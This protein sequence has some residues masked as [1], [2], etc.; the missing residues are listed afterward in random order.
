M[1]RG[2]MIVTKYGQLKS[3]FISLFEHNTDAILLLDADGYILDANPAFIELGGYVEEDFVNQHFSKFIV[4][5][6]DNNEDQRPLFCEVDLLDLRFTFITKDNTHIG[7]LMRLNPVKEN[8]TIAGYFLIIKNMTKLDKMAEHYLESELNYR[9]IAENLHDVLILMDKDKNYLYV[10]PSSYEVFKFNHTDINNRNPF[11]NIHP[12]YVNEIDMKFKAAIEKGEAFQIKLKAYHEKSGWI[13]TE[14]KGKP[15]YNK[16]GQFLHIL[17][18]ARDISKE[19]EQEET[20]K[21]LAYHD[22]LTSLP[23]RRMFVEQLEVAIQRLDEENRLFAILLLDI[24]NFKQIN[25][26]YGHE[27]GDK[28]IVEFSSRIS[29]V[30]GERGLVAR[31]GGDEFVIL[32]KD[33]MNEEQVIDTARQINELV[34]QDIQIQHTHLQITTSIGISICNRETVTAAQILR[35]ADEALYNVKDM[36]KDAFSVYRMK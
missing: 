18:I 10:S 32:M 7:C 20:L 35:Y 14:I 11:F 3:H 25:D 8:E 4:S 13:W 1:C 2:M 5:D 15:I 31:L 16:S 36:G 17:L 6:I 33:F 27:I 24:D 29:H 19:R 12:D 26:S 9:M 22:M 28:V 30:V 34:K 21:Y 23:N